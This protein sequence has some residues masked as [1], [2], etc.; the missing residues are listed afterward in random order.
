[1]D[2]KIMKKLVYEIT[3]FEDTAGAKKGSLVAPNIDVHF[4]YAV[5]RYCIVQYSFVGFHL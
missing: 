4:L 5:H 2:S 1:M 3:H